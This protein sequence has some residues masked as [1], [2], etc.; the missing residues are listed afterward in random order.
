MHSEDRAISAGVCRDVVGE[1]PERPAVPLRPLSLA[2]G[3][4]VCITPPP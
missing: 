2:I 3:G 4:A 1:L